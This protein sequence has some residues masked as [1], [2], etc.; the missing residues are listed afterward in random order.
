MG[1]G[2]SFVV[3]AGFTPQHASIYP[4]T[5]CWFSK[6]SQCFSRTTVSFCWLWLRQSAQSLTLSPA[7]EGGAQEARDRRHASVNKHL[8]AR[9]GGRCDTRPSRIIV[10]KCHRRQMY[11]VRYILLQMSNVSGDMCRMGRW[12]F[13]SCLDV[14]QSNFDEHMSRKRFS[15]FR[16]QWLWPLTFRSQICSP[17][18][19]RSL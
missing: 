1:C 7:I 9:P 13:W 11:P 15:R 14:N 4:S 5:S 10:D 19:Q 3:N 16:S 18:Y 17:S 12:S 8:G 6:V 2:L